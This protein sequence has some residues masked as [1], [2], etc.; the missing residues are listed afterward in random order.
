IDEALALTQ[1]IIE[2]ATDI[3]ER[4]W[5][6]RAIALALAGRISEAREAYT[7]ARN[8]AERVSDASSV[9]LMY[10]YQISNV[11]MPYGADNLLERRRIASEAEAA[12]RRVGAALGDV[13]PR[14][15]RLP[16]LQ[17]EG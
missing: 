4:A 7:I 3:P 14:S 10:L 6:G 17:I 9:V 1:A 2:R 8:V 13:S 11:V 5:W 15:A 12:W 16:I